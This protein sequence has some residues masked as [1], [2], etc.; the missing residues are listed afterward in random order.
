MSEA[1]RHRETLAELDYAEYLPK[2]R[3]ALESQQMNQRRTM[4]QVRANMAGFTVDAAKTPREKPMHQK[5]VLK[6]AQGEP[7]IEVTI[8]QFPNARHGCPDVLMWG[9]RFFQY[10]A[11]CGDVPHYKECFAVA[12]APFPGVDD[13]GSTV[14]QAD[15]PAIVEDSQAADMVAEGGPAFTDAQMEDSERSLRG[16][17]YSDEELAGCAREPDPGI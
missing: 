16:P 1:D 15:A 7:V 3:Q 10:E 11:H 9:D 4:E 17:D 5:A 13:N 8:L 2:F 6:T 14:R 12:V